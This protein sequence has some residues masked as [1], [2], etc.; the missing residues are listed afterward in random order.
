MSLIWTVQIMY[1]TYVGSL[2][3]TLQNSCAYH[4][5]VHIPKH[6]PA[7]TTKTAEPAVAEA[8]VS[9]MNCISAKRIDR[10]ASQLNDRFSRVK[11]PNVAYM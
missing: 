6:F 11:N 4:P 1:I 2:L 5:L 3:L 9:S 8:Y 7:V 10:A